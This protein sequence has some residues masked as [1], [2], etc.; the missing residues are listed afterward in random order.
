VVNDEP[1]LAALDV[2]EAV[3]RRQALCLSILDVGECVIAGVYR[4]TAIHT[5]QLIA[6]GNFEAGKNFK[7]RD[8]IVPER[9]LATPNSVLW[10]K[11][12]RSSATA[13]RPQS[14]GSC[15]SA[16]DRSV[17]Y[18]RSY[19]APAHRLKRL[20]RDGAVYI[21]VKSKGKGHLYR[22]TPTGED[23]RSIVELMSVWGQRWSDRGP[24]GLYP[25]MLCGD[26]TRDLSS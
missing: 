11:S 6:E 23:S 12:P 13:G 8:K 10:L 1:T 21:E 18:S 14:C 20:E 3:A 7:C 25:K 4:R 9:R 15:A 17:S 2:G 22:L 24:D 16:L 19:H 5:D 26:A